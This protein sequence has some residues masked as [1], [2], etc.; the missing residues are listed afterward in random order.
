M[1]LLLAPQTGDV[2]CNIQLLTVP[3]PGAHPQHT[4]LRLASPSTLLRGLHKSGSVHTSQL[5]AYFAAGP[6]STALTAQHST[7][8]TGHT[9]P[10]DRP[11][12]SYQTLQFSH[13]L[14]AALRLRL[15][16]Q[17]HPPLRVQPNVTSAGTPLCCPRHTAKP[18]HPHRQHARDRSQTPPQTPTAPND[19]ITPYLRLCACG[20]AYGRARR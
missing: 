13:A 19:S 11:A 10:T 2:L 14:S 6:H 20:C 17:T 18:S 16:L 1:S 5:P 8:R 15:R 12:R 4:T 9:A 7:A 3:A